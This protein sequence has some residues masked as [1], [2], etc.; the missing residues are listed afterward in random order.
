MRRNARIMAAKRERCR[1]AQVE[2]LR[3]R[4]SRKEPHHSGRPAAWPT[5]HRERK[6]TRQ[7]LALPVATQNRRGRCARRVEEVRQ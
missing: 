6:P 4:Q 2:S 3:H 7:A 1:L 5:T